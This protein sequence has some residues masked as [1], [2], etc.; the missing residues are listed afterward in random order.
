[1]FLMKCYFY[2]VAAEGEQQLTVDNLLSRQAS[3]QKATV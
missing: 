3:I 1:M 2:Q